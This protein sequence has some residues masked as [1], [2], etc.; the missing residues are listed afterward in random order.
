MILHNYQSRDLGKQV[1]NKTNIINNLGNGII[2]IISAKDIGRIRLIE[3]KKVK[4]DSKDKEIDIEIINTKMVKMRLL[5]NFIKYKE[6]GLRDERII[7]IGFNNTLFKKDKGKGFK[8]KGKEIP[9]MKRF[10]EIIKS[11]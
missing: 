2:K 11:I 10:K 7:D 3:W 9:N 6:G 8:I 4:I 5:N 1:G